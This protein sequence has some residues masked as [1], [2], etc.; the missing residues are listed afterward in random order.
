MISVASAH[1]DPAAL[2]PV[3]SARPV[4]NA[5]LRTTCV[6]TL[7]EGGHADNALPQKA[8]ATVNCRVLPGES[9]D[10]VQKTLVGVVADD[11]ISVVPIDRRSERSIAA[12]T[13]IMGAIKQVTAEFWPGIA[14]HSD[15]EHGRNRWQIFAKRRHS[16]VRPSGSLTTSTTCGL[17]ART[18]AFPL[19]PSTTDRS[20][21]IVS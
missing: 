4:Y 15:H 13:E 6:A 17:T 12:Q 2:L 7:L 11:Q 10:E 21:F 14:C 16:R 20:T 3:L 18:S 19:N 5:Q 8:Q 1:P 9:I